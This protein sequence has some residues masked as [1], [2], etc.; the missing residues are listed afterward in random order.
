MKNKIVLIVCAILFLIFVIFWV[1]KANNPSKRPKDDTTNS[2]EWYNKEVK[3]RADSAWIL[4]PEIPENYIPVPGEHEMYMVVDAQGNISEYRQRIKSEDGS[5]I[6]SNVENP[7][8]TY[9]IAAETDNGYVLSSDNGDTY[10]KYIRNDDNSYAYVNSDANG[11]DTESTDATTIPKYYIHVT[12][13]IFAVYNEFGVVTGYKERVSDGNGGYVWI[14]TSKPDTSSS[15]N[16]AGNLI[17]PSNDSNNTVDDNNT[18]QSDNNPSEK[19]EIKSDGTK[20]ITT[21]YTETKLEGN[22]HVTYKTTIT[23]TYNSSGELISTKKDGPIEVAR[24]TQIGNAGI[25]NPMSNLDDEVYRVGQMV[26]YDYDTANN[27]LAQLNELR[28]SMGLTTLSMN[29]GSLYK[30]AKIKA[31][32]M[33][34]NGHANSDSPTYGSITS[35]AKKYGVSLSND[36]ET[37][38]M[39]YNSTADAINMRLQALS[40]SREVRLDADISQIC[41]VVVQKDGYTYVYECYA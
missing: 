19:E 10:I 15:D 11:N 1:S 2:T 40:S 33:A 14:N 24:T 31:T 21:S 23:K 41:I 26:S 13:N 9:I 30:I 20:V 12:G 37:A 32:D 29:N 18:S 22:E 8:K 38:L 16:N 35:I 34:V 17:N 4:D 3:T 36:K 27:L 6:W 25:G 7:N 28:S 39:M 5:W